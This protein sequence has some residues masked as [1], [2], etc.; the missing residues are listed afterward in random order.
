MLVP[1]NAEK[2]TH[3]HDQVKGIYLLEKI[4]CKC[5][6]HTSFCLIIC[7][8][9]EQVFPFPEHNFQLITEKSKKDIISD[10]REKNLELAPEFL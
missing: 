3:E 9:C 2:C 7:A 4:P 5:G 10:L 1:K 6:G 8:K